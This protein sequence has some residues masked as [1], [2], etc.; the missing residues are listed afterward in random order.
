MKKNNLFALAIMATLIMSCT[1]ESAVSTPSVEIRSQASMSE[2]II[3]K[4]QL[5]DYGTVTI[6]SPNNYNSSTESSNKNSCGYGTPTTTV[7]WI[8]F[9]DEIKFDFTKAGDYTRYMNGA[10]SCS[11][12]YKLTTADLILQANC[13]AGQFGI[14][15]FSKKV[16]V[17]GDGVR[18][19]RYEKI[20]KD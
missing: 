13:S 5:K 9:T 11:G 17:V 2:M 3:G 15:D 1:K 19:Y 20:D 4:W 7:T 10:N 6:T 12:S 18:L 14:H 16:F 8:A